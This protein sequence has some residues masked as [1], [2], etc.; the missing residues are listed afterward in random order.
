MLSGI[1]NPDNLSATL[2]DLSQRRRQGVLEVT[3]PDRK[4]EVLVV[5]GRIVDVMDVDGNPFATVVERLRRAGMLPD[6]FTLPLECES[7]KELFLKINEQVVVEQ[8]TFKLAIK[9]K[10]LDQLYQIEAS[11]GGFFSFQV[12]MIEF[13][14]EF[15]P[16][17][18]VGQ[19]L[20]DIVALNSDRERFERTFGAE[21][22]IRAAKLPDGAGQ[23][24]SEEE[25][26]L[27][28]AIGDA[29]AWSELKH[30]CLLS[31]FHVQD[32]LL[33]FKDSGR[34]KLEQVAPVERNGHALSLDKVAEALNRSI[35]QS[36][37]IPEHE[38]QV[39][40]AA[41]ASLH[42]EIE[43]PEVAYAVPRIGLRVK[44]NLLNM[45]L[46][47]NSMI[48]HLVQIIFLLAAL[49]IPL[50]LWLNTLGEL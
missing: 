49:T 42:E 47:Q 50:G 39:E 9:H 2:R 35:D 8:S 7:Y 14:R 10:V 32:T 48:P 19:L 38:P 15:S 44:L 26:A 18:S 30:K 21:T 24:H 27:L 5:Q 23:N 31:A 6:E 17:I 16:N 46:L 22:L 33:A 43:Q 25:Q 4:V 20:L 37:G 36:F 29:I 3:L 12:R 1:L 28:D 11:G 13:D 34:I 41:E 40:L 45:R